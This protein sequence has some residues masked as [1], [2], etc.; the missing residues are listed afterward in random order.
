MGVWGREVGSCHCWG[1]AE[2]SAGVEAGTHQAPPATAEDFSA[3]QRWCLDGYWERWCPGGRGHAGSEEVLGCVPVDGYSGV[4]PCQVYI[5]CTSA[6]CVSL[7]PG[8]HVMARPRAGEADL[9]CTVMGFGAT[10]GC[11][12]AALAS[13]P[14]LML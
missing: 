2:G 13:D 11:S 14:L 1:R 5:G 10:R 8:L 12:G 9:D 3:E 4:V 6:W 7:V